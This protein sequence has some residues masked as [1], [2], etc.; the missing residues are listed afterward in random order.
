[1]LSDRMQEQKTVN[2][3]IESSENNPTPWYRK[4]KFAYGLYLAA[5]IGGVLTVG[6]GKI[7]LPSSWPDMV[8]ETAA[9][10][11]LIAGFLIRFFP[12]IAAVW[13]H[14]LARWVLLVYGAMATVIATAPAKHIVSGALQLPATDFTSTLA[15]WTL[16]CA[17]QLWLSGAAFAAT[18]VYALLLCRIFLEGLFVHSLLGAPV[19]IGMRLFPS[20]RSWLGAKESED[21]SSFLWTFLDCAAAASLALVLGSSVDIAYN[22]VNRPRLVRLFAF[23]AD[24]ETASAYPGVEP[25]EAY[26]LHANNVVSYARRAS[27]DVVIRTDQVRSPSFGGGH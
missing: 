11:A 9:V 3:N 21:V 10:C 22:A 18:G 13:R 12:V 20:L 23:Y 6:I 26:V 24:Y 7:Y 16:L 4:T 25:G 17:P 19:R 8:L 14:P 27:H 5:L 2:M 1:M 15:F